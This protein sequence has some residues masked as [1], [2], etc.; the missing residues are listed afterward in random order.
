M[1]YFPFFVDLSGKRGL[2][3]GG[4]SVAARK[5]EKLLPYGPSLTVIAPRIGDGIRRH[6]GL[7]F[8]ERPF[9][10][11]D[12]DACHFAIAATD[13]GDL[14]AHIA[15]LCRSRGIPVNAVDD[16]E[17]S[18][19]LFPALVR[20]GALSIGI[21]TGG[22]SPSAAVYVK[23]QIEDILPP[24]FDAILSF[25]YAQRKRVHTLLPDG[26]QRARLMK[27]LLTACL[28]HGGPLTADE[29]EQYLCQ[30]QEI[31]R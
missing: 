28:S 1:A 14:N 13:C 12:L 22:C 17:N 2:V 5:V 6:G 18:T 11:D 8:W 20:Q 19:F 26:Q 21:S 25:L 3:V 27:A 10:Q 15:D 31:C 9:R 7:V 29:T 23:E 16:A 30:A 4:G 24:D